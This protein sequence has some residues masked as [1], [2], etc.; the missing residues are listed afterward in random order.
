M[1]SMPALVESQALFGITDEE[2]LISG[3]DIHDFIN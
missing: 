1:L 3:N 2:L